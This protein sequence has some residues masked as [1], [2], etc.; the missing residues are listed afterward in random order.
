MTTHATKHAPQPMLPIMRVLGWEFL[1]CVRLSGVLY[2][3]CALLLPWVLFRVIL[4][5]QLEHFKSENYY[6]AFYGLTVFLGLIF[7]YEAQ[8]GVRQFLVTR[9]LTT[10][11]MFCW[12]LCIPIAAVA[13]TFILANALVQTAYG[14][15]WPW[16]RPLLWLVFFVV[17]IKCSY[18]RVMVGRSWETLLAIAIGA[19]A[20]FCFAWVQGRDKILLD[21]PLTI[22]EVALLGT[23]T[24]LALIV[25]YRSFA[26]IRT[27]CGDKGSDAWFAQRY[28]KVD[29]ALVEMV[30]KA[31]AETSSQTA[32][33]Q[34]TN[35]RDA[36]EWIAW[37]QCGV[38][39]LSI[40][41]MMALLS[42]AMQINT[43]VEY[44]Q[45]PMLFSRPDDLF[46]FTVV[47][48]VMSC[49]AAGVGIGLLTAT[50][51]RT[52][53][54]TRD[55]HMST[56]FAAR[57]ISNIELWHV[58]GRTMFRYAVLAWLLLA[59]LLS[60][61][62]MLAFF[63][64]ESSGPFVYGFQEE[65]L[66]Y[67]SLG[68]FSIAAW[69]LFGFLVMWTCIG[70]TAS[71]M[72]FG[73]DRATTAIFAAV[74]GVLVT[75]C[76]VGLAFP[77]QREMIFTGTWTIFGAI[78]FAA[79]AWAFRSAIRHKFINRQHIAGAVLVWAM[80]AAFAVNFV[81]SQH[82]LG[83]VL[84]SSLAT[85]GVAAGPLGLTASRSR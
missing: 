81:A 46:E 53:G 26:L 60:I 76:F 79:T 29:L 54:K 35:S 37:R 48:F 18:W 49:F 56:F 61:L 16:I 6:P 51:I 83:A 40:T 47:M 50:M 44:S 41:V 72:F 28:G 25:G 52:P 67:S 23:A 22:A 13:T 21:N 70:V 2:L 85:F 55:M 42:I 20:V 32:L 19:F 68:P 78:A 43:V 59:V 5:T 36:L 30:S 8:K 14:V 57:P 63:G 34:L 77:E 64:R 45:L 82:V 24:V 71:G 3:L 9:P 58:L 10:E 1:R 31:E 4:D 69:L 27:T 11:F 7:A 39:A 66:F 17:L 38:S 75:I 15:H 62:P 33:A 84:L 74:V 73:N 80:S 65:N 12:L